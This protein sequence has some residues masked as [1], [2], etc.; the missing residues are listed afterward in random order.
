MNTLGVS[1]DKSSLI[2]FDHGMLEGMLWRRRQMHGSKGLIG[3][4]A[5]HL[6]SS[7]GKGKQVS[8]ARSSWNVMQKSAVYMM[9][10]DIHSARPWPASHTDRVQVDVFSPCYM[11]CHQINSLPLSIVSFVFIWGFFCSCMNALDFS[12]SLILLGLFGTII[13][14]E[15]RDQNAWIFP[16]CFYCSFLS[17]HNFF[18]MSD[19]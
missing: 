5:L 16:I 11:F 9:D 14:N 4:K 10:V 18:K 3:W 19:R 12:I 15:L 2:R 1:R 7:A 13:C 8:G 17:L 6:P